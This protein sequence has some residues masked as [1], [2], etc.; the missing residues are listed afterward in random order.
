MKFNLS[1]SRQPYRKDL[2]M[3]FLTIHKA[4][5]H[6]SLIFSVYLSVFTYYLEIDVQFGV[7][8]ILSQF[9]LPVWLYGSFIVLHI[10][11]YDIVCF[12]VVNSALY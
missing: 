12:L 3:H 5:L 2:N 10:I 9:C 8:I 11:L 4:I 7:L 6:E 1:Y